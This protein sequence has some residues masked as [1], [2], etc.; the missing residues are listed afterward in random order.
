MRTGIIREIIIVRV[1]I[2]MGKITEV[3][4]RIGVVITTIIIIEINGVEYVV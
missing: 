1:T 3:L 4:I 2:I